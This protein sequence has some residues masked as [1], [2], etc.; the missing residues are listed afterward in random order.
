MRV[1]STEFDPV[2]VGI[3][4]VLGAI[5]IGLAWLLRDVLVEAPSTAFPLLFSVM[6]GGVLV[7]VWVSKKRA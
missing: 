1:G 4:A 3:T 6:I 2:V 5:A 7:A